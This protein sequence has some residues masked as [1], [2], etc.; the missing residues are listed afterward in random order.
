MFA[1][2]DRKFVGRRNELP[3]DRIVGI[4]G[5]DQG[6]DIRRHRDRIA[7]RDLF[8]IGKIGRPAQAHGHQFGG[9]P[10][11]RCCIDP[12][13]AVIRRR[14]PHHLIDPQAPLASITSRSK[15]SATPL[16]CGI[17]ADGIKK[18]L[19]ERIAFA[20]A[21]LLFVHGQR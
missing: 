20:V 18:V 12:A 4:V 1:R 5:I 6:R 15:P 16:A 8:E 13:H 19:V 14:R 10:Q 3:R 11:G 2:L 9:L 7:R 17:C 21:P